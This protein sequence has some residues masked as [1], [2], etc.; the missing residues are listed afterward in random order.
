MKRKIYLICGLFLAMVMMGACANYKKIKDVECG[1]LS[2]NDSS[3]IRMLLDISKNDTSYNLQNISIDYTRYSK[4]GFYL[5]D[6]EN[7]W[8]LNFSDKYF[9]IKV[10]YCD[11]NFLGLYCVVSG[12]MNGLTLFPI[13]NNSLYVV[14]R[15]LGKKVLDIQSKEGI[16]SAII[17]EG[18]LYFGC[19]EHDD[20]RYVKM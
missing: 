19:Y 17:K 13:T 20:I 18:I 8:E 7:K 11:S 15:K 3:Q 12:I 10:M 16:S 6:K 1:V 4:S 9:D 2:G 5:I 14:N